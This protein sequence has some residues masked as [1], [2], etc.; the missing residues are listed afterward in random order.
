MEILVARAS[1]MPVVSLLAA[2]TVSFLARMLVVTG[3]SS[4]RLSMAWSARC[5]ITGPTPWPSAVD[6]WLCRA[7]QTAGPRPRLRDPRWW[8]HEVAQ[9]PRGDCGRGRSARSALA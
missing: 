3:Y 5:A 2:W 1:A 8:R 6:G 7:A 9:G 4:L